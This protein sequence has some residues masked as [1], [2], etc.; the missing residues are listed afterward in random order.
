[1]FNNLNSFFKSI[2]TSFVISLLV[3]VILA[4]I[5]HILWK[6]NRTEALLKSE[7][8]QSFDEVKIFNSKN[9]ELN[10]LII[11]EVR[12]L[13]KELS[14]IFGKIDTNAGLNIVIFEKL[15]ELQKY[16]ELEDIGAFFDN[17]ANLIALVSPD[18]LYREADE[19]F[20]RKDLRHEYTHYFLAKYLIEKKIKDVPKW[21]DEGVAEY[22]AVTMDGVEATDPLNE[23]INFELLKSREDWARQ[24]RN[25][26][27]LYPQSH[28]GIRYIIEKKD[29]D[30]LKKII[31]DSYDLGFSKSFKRHTNIE[32]NE[33]HK[34]IN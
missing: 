32:I 11:K 13:N 31:D 3:L 5:Y 24:R 17:N 30:I 15:E 33:L 19:W 34:F 20:F 21:F 4:S 16:G 12:D 10:N 22:V 29:L 2:T 6:N 26:K 23:V 9:N 28:Y 7:V 1:M 14:N 18:S 27:E 25:H 8:H